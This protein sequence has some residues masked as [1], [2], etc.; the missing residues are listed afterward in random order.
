MVDQ[1]ARQYSATRIF[2]CRY[3]RHPPQTAK[4]GVILCDQTL[5]IMR[6]LVDSP[7][8]DCSGWRSA[9]CASLK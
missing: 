9:A 8:C 6:M 5:L 1:N 3:L 7:A 4:T 2:F